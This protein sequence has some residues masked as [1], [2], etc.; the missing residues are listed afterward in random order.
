M[1]TKTATMIAAASLLLG[2]TIGSMVSL[3]AEHERYS[4]F[5]D[6]DGHPGQ[7]GDI[8][9]GD[10]GQI[11][12]VHGFTSTLQAGTYAAYGYQIQLCPTCNWVETLPSGSSQVIPA[13]PQIQHLSTFERVLNYFDLLAQGGDSIVWGS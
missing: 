4:T 1:R 2:L 6:K 9:L 13:G 3:H 11:I 12:K 8:I 5:Y 10:G 7:I